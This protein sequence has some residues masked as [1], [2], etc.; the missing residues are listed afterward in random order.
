MAL[1]GCTRWFERPGE[2]EAAH[3]TAVPLLQL[4][5][6]TAVV[7]AIIHMRPCVPFSHRFTC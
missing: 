2:H 1:R 5:Y 3:M 4:P 7:I 6:P